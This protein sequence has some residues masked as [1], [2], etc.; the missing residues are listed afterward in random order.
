MPITLTAPPAKHDWNA[1]TRHRRHTFLYCP[2]DEIL[3]H[4]YWT[5]FQHR[6]NDWYLI[7]MGKKLRDVGSG[8]MTIERLIAEAY[9]Q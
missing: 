4:S 6:G 7:H 9:E 3:R 8:I 5:C 1:D 2:S